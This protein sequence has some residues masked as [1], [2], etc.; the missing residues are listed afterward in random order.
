MPTNK[1]LEAELN[2]ARAEIARLS[3]A[4]EGR[5][6]PREAMNGARERLDSYAE[7][8]SAEA[9]DVY[10]GA[11]RQGRALR[12]TA[13]TQVRENPVA[14]LGLAVLFGAVLASWLGR[15]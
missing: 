7:D 15:R 10:D 3:A 12:A 14:S 4:I 9:R 11:R 5:F 13:E 8:L 2:E 1:E 6:S